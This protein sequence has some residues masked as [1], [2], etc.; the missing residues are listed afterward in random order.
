MN[1]DKEKITILI[2]DDHTIFRSGLKLLLSS[3]PNM[4]IVGEAGDGKEALELIEKLKPKVVLMDISMPNMNG[5]EATKYIKRKCPEVNVIILTMHDDE[6]FLFNIVNAGG[7]GYLLKEVADTNLIYAI[8]EVSKGEIFIMP[9]ITKILV[10]D[11]LE[12]IKNKEE[13]KN[14]ASLTKREEEILSMI[15]QGH[16]NQSIADEFF[17]SIRT[18][19]THRAH[20]MEKLRIKTRVELVNYAHRKHLIN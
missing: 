8:E 10:K 18:V 13:L 7:S 20:I 1:K 15:A 16:T 11:Y 19:E 9:N 14:L 4:E 3:Q 6:I 12:R 2:V 17:I 5:I